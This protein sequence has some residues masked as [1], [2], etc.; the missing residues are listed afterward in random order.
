MVFLLQ[1]AL[2]T[3]A[4]SATFGAASSHSINFATPKKGLAFDVAARSLPRG[5]QVLFGEDEDEEEE[6]DE[7]EGAEKDIRQHPEYDKL[8]SY[9]MKQQVLLQLRATYL[10]E[11]LSRRGLP[12][13]SLKDVSTPEGKTPPKKVDWDCAMS[14][15]AN[16]K[17]CLISYEPETGSKVVVPMDLAHTDKWITLKELN[18]LRRKDPS[19]VDPMWADQ[20]AVLSSWFDPNSRYSMLQ[21]VGIKGVILSALLDGHRLPFVVGLLLIGLTIQLMPIIEVFT[22]RFVVSSFVWTRWPS[23]YHYARVGLPFKILIIQLLGGQLS[24]LFFKLTAAIKTKLVDLECQI[25]EKTI[26]L[27]VGEGSQDAFED[28]DIQEEEE[29]EVDDILDGDSA[30]EEEDDEE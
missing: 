19:K 18:R 7:E 14:T 20:Y 3:A 12:I 6:N 28:V 16:P 25:F 10:S 9:Q 5:G 29:D 2:A 23:W 11:A 27:T 17:P 26:P 8:R 1:L 21:H 30:A 15:E 22:N 24:K 13:A 4:S